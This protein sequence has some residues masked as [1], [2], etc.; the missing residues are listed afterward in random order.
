MMIF[1]M[2]EKLIIYQLLVRLAGNK[3]DNNKA[4]GT[5]AENGCGKFN[6]LSDH[7]LNEIASLGANHIWLTGVIEHASCTAYP[8]HN[9]PGDNPLTVKGRAGSPYAIRDYYDVCP[10]LALDVDKRMDEF[11]ALI[12]RCYKAG[13]HPVIDFVPNHV[14]RY[15]HSDHPA[16]TDKD[17]G[18]NDNSDNAFDPNN[19]FYYIPGTTLELPPETYALAH[20]KDIGANHFDENP[21]KATGNDCF[22]H[23]PSFHDW[24]ETVKLNYGIDYLH[25]RQEHFD[26]IPDTWH[27][28][29]DILL[30]WADKKVAGFRCDMAEMVP[31]AFWHWLIAKV[32]EKHP[33]ILFI[34]EIYDPHQYVMFIDAGFDYLYDKVGLYD[35][36]RAVL[37]GQQTTSSITQEWQKLNGL[38]AKMLRFI[39]NHD[40]QRIASD[41]FAGTAWAGIPAMTLAATMHQGPVMIYFGQEHGENAAGATGFSGDDGRTSIFDY[42]NVPEFQKWFNGGRCN[43]ENLFQEA[44][45]LRNFYRKLFKLSKHNVISKGHFYDLMWANCNCGHTSI[46]A[47]IRWD[48]KNVW[49]I[50]VNFSNNISVNCNIHI[51]EHFW[52]LTEKILNNKEWLFT[53][54]LRQEKP[55]TYTRTKTEENGVPVYL[56]AYSSEILS[57]KA[58]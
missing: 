29:L 42:C 16:G 25:G 46:F 6:D 26:P 1:L 28:M 22:S 39:E 38:D 43:D 10:D 17:F 41:H 44:K 32:R 4:W 49:L 40:E 19:N 33:K 15:Y 54:L 35:A 21:A 23:R 50:M 47:Y 45:D 53:P 48:H 11:E 27:K 3:L 7:F 37:A 12:R 30:F 14:A 51:P 2:K 8:D 55:F 5:I 52:K 9:I 36:V 13:L 20:A 58:L 18:K 56:P 57:I 34:A 31:A 24:Y